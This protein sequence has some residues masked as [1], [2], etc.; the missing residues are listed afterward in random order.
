MAVKGLDFTN[1]ETDKYILNYVYAKV[2]MVDK[3]Q[4]C[5]ERM[6]QLEDKEPVIGFIIEMYTALGETDRAIE[7]L[8]K[9]FL[10]NS[11]YKHEISTRRALDPLRDDPRYL[12][13]VERMG[14]EP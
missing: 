5:L 3:A 12:E 7:W 13:L 9:V 6:L 14:L 4:E 8:E 1:D 10:T 2:G 11:S